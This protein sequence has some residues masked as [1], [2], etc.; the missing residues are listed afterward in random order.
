MTGRGAGL[1]TRLRLVGDVDD[2]VAEEGHLLLFGVHVN[3]RP[4]W[5]LLLRLWRKRWVVLYGTTGLP[6][7][8]RRHLDIQ[9]GVGGRSRCS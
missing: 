6:A 3:V 9:S 1:E 8:P 2:H 5:V 4:M 7:L